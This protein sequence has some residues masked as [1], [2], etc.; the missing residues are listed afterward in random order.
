MLIRRILFSNLDEMEDWV[1]TGESDE[2]TYYDIAYTFY[3]YEKNITINLKKFSER[4][5]IS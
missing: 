5:I 4:H 2:Q 1:I 3:K